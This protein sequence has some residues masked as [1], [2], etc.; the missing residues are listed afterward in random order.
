MHNWACRTGWVWVLTF[1]NLS[2]LPAQVSDHFVEEL[3]LDEEETLPAEDLFIIESLQR[4]GGV[5]TPEALHQLATLSF[6][7]AGDVKLLRAWGD[8]VDCNRLYQEEA[9]SPKLRLLLDEI[10]REHPKAPQPLFLRQRMTTN[11]DVRY[12]WR[13]EWTLSG[14]RLGFFIERDP[15]E[16]RIADRASGY[17]SGGNRHNQWVIGDH[18]LIL[19]YGLLSWRSVAVSKGFESIKTLPRRGNGLR[20]YRSSD[21]FWN[22]RG[23]G[24]QRETSLGTGG[25]SLGNNLW[26]G[27]VDST[28]IIHLNLTG[29]H[30][31]NR[32]SQVLEHS[33]IGFWEWEQEDN[34]LGL[35]FSTSQWHQNEKRQR[36]KAAAFNFQYR[37]WNWSLFGEA[38]RGYGS[39]WGYLT[40]ARFHPRGFYYLICI[41][42]YTNPYYALRSNPFS[43]WS[44]QQ[45]NERGIYQ[46]VQWNWRQHQITIYGDI[47]RA[48]EAAEDRLAAVRGQ[49]TGIRWQWYRRNL[50]LK[51]QWKQEEKTL[52][53]LAT[54]VEIQGTT[55]SKKDAWKGMIYQR[56]GDRYD[57]KGQINISRIGTADQVS[58][59]YGVEN[60]WSGKWPPWMMT[61]DWIVTRV[62]QYESRVYFWDINLPGEMRSVAYTATGQSWGLRV[63]YRQGPHLYWGLR[64]RSTWKDLLFKAPLTVTGSLVLETVL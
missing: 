64:L 31:S 2:Q 7:S 44:G 35:A 9:L 54:F 8:S 22:L 24:F 18:E 57:W 26:D 4:G 59:G 58:T 10:R 48:G 50:R 51:L 45:R 19:G 63:Q 56:F 33:F 39:H 20:S 6:L 62:D 43:E 40:G 28:G 25:F 16:T 23:V 29:I 61:V 11:R 17:F 32:K 46:G 49:E 30:T 14:Q 12:S 13:G 3:G 52:E 42:S 41:R 36:K 21:E 60:L 15:G 38:A 34:R 47:Y 1:L 5:L 27:Y 37:L 55:Y 53:P